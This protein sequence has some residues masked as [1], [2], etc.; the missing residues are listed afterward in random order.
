MA[1]FAVST[2]IGAGV[3]ASA[4]KIGM[5]SRHTTDALFIAQAWAER[6]AAAEDPIEP[7]KVRR[8]R[9]T[10]GGYRLEE[11]GYTID[12]AGVSRSKTGAGTLYA[13]RNHG[14]TLGRGADRRFRPAGTCRGR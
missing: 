2:V 7:L 11:D 14:F 5:D 3:L 10:E 12:G 9:K 8:A 4:Y 6:V 13:I 1:F